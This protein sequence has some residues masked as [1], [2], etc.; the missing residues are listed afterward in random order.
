ME[1]D[2]RSLA[3]NKN[4]NPL[5]SRQAMR[6]LSKQVK[7]STV[8]PK[9]GMKAGILTISDKGARQERVDTSGPAVTAVLAEIGAIIEKYEIIPDEQ[10]VIARKLLNTRMTCALIW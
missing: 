2:L 6:I 5:I 7:Y 10:D 8:K 4:V 1:K 3:K 9:C